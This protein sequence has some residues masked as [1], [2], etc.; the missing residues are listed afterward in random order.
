MNPV[1]TAE[2]TAIQAEAANAACDLSCAI[3]RTTRTRGPQ[4]GATP[5]FSTLYT[6]N[7]GMSEPTAGQLAN[8]DFMIG[9][10]ATWQVKFAVGT[11]VKEQDRLVIAGQTLTVKK[12]LAPR[13]YPTLLTC[14]ASELK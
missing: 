5:T 8:Y 2:L 9:D 4:G 13:S 11:D 6:V 12:I 7:A 1:S 3:Q 14:L 10:L